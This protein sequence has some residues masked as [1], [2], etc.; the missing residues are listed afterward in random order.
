M[1][2]DTDVEK[3]GIIRS[4]TVWLGHVFGWIWFWTCLALLALTVVIFVALDSWAGAGPAII[5]CWISLGLLAL[6]SLPVLRTRLLSA[7]STLKHPRRAFAA[8]VGLLL[9]GGLGAGLSAAAMIGATLPASQVAS[10]APSI[11]P[12]ATVS[13]AAPPPA[14]QS[15]GDDLTE[16]ERRKAQAIVGVHRGVV[17]TD[18]DFDVGRYCV[19]Q[20]RTG[21]VT[22]EECLGIAAVKLAA[23][24]Q[25]RR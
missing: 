3:P 6:I 1:T 2:A 20:A 4:F 17:T 9:L 21:D 19:E 7:A 14:D 11:S 22:F 8:L 10:P 24:Y 13:E 23:E 12:V 15:T 5:G 18:P 16:Q 25:P